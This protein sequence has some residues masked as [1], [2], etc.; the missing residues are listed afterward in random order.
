MVRWAN[1]ES[2]RHLFRPFDSKQQAARRT[3]LV[4][5]ATRLAAALEAGRLM[6][7]IELDGKLVGEV[8]LVMNPPYLHEP[9]GET[10]WFGIVLGEAH[11][12]GQ[13]IGRK[14]MEYIED[15][16]RDR[17]AQWA[18]IGA[19]EFNQ[20]ARQLYENLGYQEIA[21]IANITWWKG[22]RWTDIRM[23]KA[24]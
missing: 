13:G 8:N 2:I 12:R 17:G 4:G 1:D 14:A 11:A 15:V 16:A 22:K 19:F 18:Q 6:Y 10:A 3:D 21:R 24:L 5:A 9:Q 23:Q 7:L 20:R